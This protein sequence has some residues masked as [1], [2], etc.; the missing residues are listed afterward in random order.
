MQAGMTKIGELGFYAAMARTLA[1]AFP[2]VAPY[3]SFVP[4][5]GT[6]WG[7][8]VAAKAD[9]PRT[10]A[11][12]T[13]DARIRE[14]VTGEL[15]FYDGQAHQHLFSL[16]KFLRQAVASCDRVATDSEP[17]LVR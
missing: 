14:R 9:D 6:P 15:G 11:P 7:F 13:I 8:I 17:L 16:P 4:C 12:A 10:L 3:Q 2:V 5:F 1:E